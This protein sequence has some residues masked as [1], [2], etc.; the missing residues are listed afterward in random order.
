M[1]LLPAVP[2]AA[3]A[4]KAVPL[5]R[6]VTGRIGSAGEQDWYR[7]ELRQPGRYLIRLT[8]LPANL[9]LDL[10]NSRGAT[11]GTSARPSQQF[12]EIDRYL[13]AG[14]YRVRVASQDGTFSTTRYYHLR[15]SYLPRGLDVLSVSRWRIGA[16]YNSFTVASDLVNNTKRWQIVVRIDV[17]LVDRSGRV[18]ADADSSSIPDVI[19][20]HGHAVCLAEFPQRYL[21]RLDHIRVVVGHYEPTAYRNP[22]IT[23]LPGTAVANPAGGTDFRGFLRNDGRTGVSHPGVTVVLYGP[24]GR[25][26]D[27]QRGFGWETRVAPG[28]TTPYQVTSQRIGP[29]AFTRAFPDAVAG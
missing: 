23:V 6:T 17:Q 24:A 2:A 22:P 4:P 5:G 8:T 25:I 3:A 19:A 12:E 28:R 13:V 15:F 7:F 20:P 26:R 29:W 1:L 9:R 14:T 10:V 11:I 21:R 18:Y 16:P 27:V